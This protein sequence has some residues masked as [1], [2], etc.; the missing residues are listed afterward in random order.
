MNWFLM[1][2][3]KQRI[4]LCFQILA[5]L[6]WRG[7]V[8][9]TPASLSCFKKKKNQ[10]AFFCS[11]ILL[12][13]VCLWCRIIQIHCRLSAL[14]TIHLWPQWKKCMTL[15]WGPKDSVSWMC[16]CVC[17]CV[18]KAASMHLLHRSTLKP[19]SLSHPQS[20][21]LETGRRK[22]SSYLLQ[23]CLLSAYETGKPVVLP[24]Q[25]GHFA[26]TRKTQVNNW[27]VWITSSQVSNSRTKTQTKPDSACIMYIFSFAIGLPTI[28]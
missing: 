13:S 6:W 1:N 26:S 8:S 3:W 24:N 20:W 4:R 14:S 16:V 5:L 12:F 28:T 23:R 19:P 9:E 2:E 15:L 27:R 17:I 25:T 21:D 10:C 11:Y 7:G 18:V 22:P